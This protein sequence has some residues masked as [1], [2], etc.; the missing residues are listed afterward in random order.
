ME[1]GAPLP[2]GVMICI[3]ETSSV[4]GVVM[5]GTRLWVI[6]PSIVVCISMS[7]NTGAQETRLTTTGIDAGLVHPLASVTDTEYEPL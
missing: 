7:E 1:A 3:E 6:W 2:G 5:D 4:P